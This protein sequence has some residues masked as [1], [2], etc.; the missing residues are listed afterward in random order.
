M[1]VNDLYPSKYA[2]GADLNGR[3]V[4]LAISHL[5]KEKMTPPGSAPVEKWVL[6]F[7]HAKRGV[8]LSRTLAVQI[9]HILNTEETDQWHGQKITLFPEAVMVAGRERIAIRAR[10]VDE[11]SKQT[12]ETGKENT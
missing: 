9:A 10:Q 11:Q 6:Y 3:P 1:N 8:V 12:T 7:D 4:T 2:T 5:N